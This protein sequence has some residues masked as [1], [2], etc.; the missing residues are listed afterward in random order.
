MR[1]IL[2]YLKEFI[3]AVDKRML[4]FC[5]LLAATG[6]FINYHFQLNRKINTTPRQIQY[7]SW[8]LVFFIAFA[9]PYC[10]CSFLKGLRL[11]TNANFITLVLLAPALFAWKMAFNINIHLSNSNELNTYYNQVVYWPLKLLIVTLILVVIWKIYN[12][13]KSFSGTVFS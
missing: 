2:S 10:I 3:I 12:L 7:V 6:I 4:L 5:C 13:S 8:Y 11:F 1:S 9:I